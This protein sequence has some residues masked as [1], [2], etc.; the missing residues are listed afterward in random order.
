MTQ[1]LAQALSAETIRKPMLKKVSAR[2]TG[3]LFPG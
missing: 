1:A 2:R 3:D